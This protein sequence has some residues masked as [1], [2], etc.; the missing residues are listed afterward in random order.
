M[1]FHKKKQKNIMCDLFPVLLAETLPWRHLADLHVM[2]SSAAVAML[3]WRLDK[4]RL[5]GI[6]QQEEGR[7]V[8]LLF[9]LR[10]HSENE[11]R[12]ISYPYVETY[13]YRL[14]WHFSS[15]TLL[16]YFWLYTLIL[17]QR[18]YWPV[19]TGN[20]GKGKHYNRSNCLINSGHPIILL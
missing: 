9:T 5:A 8:G 15:R 11:R 3:G 13:T 10:S 16:S 20:V 17:I 14:S 2:L 12:A 18:Q 7:Y 19:I 6:F 4:E 1:G